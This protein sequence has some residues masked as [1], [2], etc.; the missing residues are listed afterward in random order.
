MNG[1]CK[2]CGKEFEKI[3]GSQIYCSKSCRRKHEYN[4]YKKNHKLI[5]IKPKKCKICKKT[6]VPSVYN[7]LYC[8]DKCWKIQKNKVRRNK[9]MIRLKNHKCE[10]CNNFYDKTIS[11]QR[12]CSKDCRIKSYIQN[13]KNKINILQ[14]KYRKNNP[15]RYKKYDKKKNKKNSKN[16]DYIKKQKIRSHKY[17]V[18]NKE[19][20]K[21]RIQIYT[22][23]NYSKYLK[24]KNKYRN[25]RRK[26]DV[27]FKLIDNIRR[28]I[29]YAIKVNSKS[30]RTIQLLGCSTTYL[31]HHLESKFTA[32]MSWDNYGVKGWHIDHL[33]PC[34]SF[35]LSKPEEQKKCFH[36]TNL[37]PLWAKDNLSKGAKLDWSGSHD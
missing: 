26:N 10:F 15:E 17:Y 22:E 13:N 19:K 2:M 5:P 25:R 34:A 9:N 12:F 4:I 6:F 21:T 14:K 11:F 24:R 28:R 23:K 7:Q 37:Q 18:K 30:K 29:N 32:G 3:H 8:S 31:K 35:D 27:N 36:Y 16:P 33:I 1:I 20:I